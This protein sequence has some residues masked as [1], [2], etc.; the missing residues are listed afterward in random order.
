MKLKLRKRSNAREWQ[1]AKM[2][3]AAPQSAK[4]TLRKA[5]SGTG[6]ARNAV[7]AM[8]LTCMGY[9]R[10]AVKTCTGYSCPLWAFRPY[11]EKARTGI[12]A[13]PPKTLRGGVSG[14]QKPRTGPGT[15]KRTQ[16]SA[17]WLK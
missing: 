6:G 16:G 1:I 11:T 2:I 14:P 4:N 17:A 15:T 9:D 3:D 7:K 8:C 10:N 13:D 5:F 12:G